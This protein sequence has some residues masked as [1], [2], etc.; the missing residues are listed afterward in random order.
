M[1]ATCSALRMFVHYLAWCASY[2]IKVR[3]FRVDPAREWL[4]DPLRKYFD[5]KGVRLEVIPPRQ[6]DANGVAERCV[7]LFKQT[8]R[9]LMLDS[10]APHLLWRWPCSTLSTSTT[11][12]RACRLVMSMGGWCYPGTIL[13]NTQVLMNF[14]S[15]LCLTFLISSGFDRSRFLMWI[16]KNYNASSIG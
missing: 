5:A 12:F 10:N 6:Q 2:D 13:S 4:M 15:I 11:R 1:V 7:Q 3:A 14:T 8:A 16:S 9:A